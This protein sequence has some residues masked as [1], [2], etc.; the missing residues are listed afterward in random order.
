MEFAKFGEYGLLGLVIG[1]I[2]LLLFLVIKWTLAT[3]KEI[4]AQAAK[5]RECFVQKISDMTKAM[6][7]RSVNDREFHIQVVEAHKYQ[8]DEHSAQNKI[9]GELIQAVGRINGYTH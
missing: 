3:T 4:L 5:E 9:L 7:E 8:R 6:D 2:I 1:S